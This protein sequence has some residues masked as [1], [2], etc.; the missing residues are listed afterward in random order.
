MNRFK[1][2]EII[3]QYGFY[4]SGT[5]YIALLINK[6]FKN[7][8]ILRCKK[9]DG[10]TSLEYGEIYNRTQFALEDY[11]NNDFVLD[12]SSRG[13]S[14]EEINYLN[15][16]PF[17]KYVIIIKDP[18][19]WCQRQLTRHPNRPINFSI[20]N[21]NKANKKYYEFWKARHHDTDCVIIKY[22]DL[23]NNFK[24]TMHKI[25]DTLRLETKHDK[26]INTNEF[27]NDLHEGRKP[28][29]KDF[30]KEWHRVDKIVKA[31]EFIARLVTRFVDKQVM[32]W[33][34]YEVRNE[35]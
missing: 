2:K 14:E 8:M 10:P 13:V 16:H 32:D 11:Y 26:F 22:E 6:N 19:V 12:E 28:E 9:H 4:H 21:W 34:G 27:S 25:E 33:Y 29:I 15:A 7:T 24:S 20:N 31:S 18:Y 5:D 3:Q 17:V 1:D 23:L 35:S 30:L